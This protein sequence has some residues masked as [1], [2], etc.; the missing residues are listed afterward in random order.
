M[1]TFGAKSLE[2]LATCDERLQKVFTEVIKHFDCTVL[3]GH[4]GQEAQDKAFR[5]GKSKLKW[6]EGQHNA[7]PSRAVD[8]VPYPI[9]WNDTYRMRY[10]AGFVKGI[11]CSM[12]I[13]LRWGGDWDSDTELLD[14]TFFDFP[15]FEVHD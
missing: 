15:H 9:N 12:G 6:P 3:E 1:P 13:E 10:F 11:A 7:T 5:E 4:R 8:V 14:Q 2:Q